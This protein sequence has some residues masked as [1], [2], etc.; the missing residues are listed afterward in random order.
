MDNII[1]ITGAGTIWHDAMMTA[2]QGQPVQQFTD[3]GGVV[4]NRFYRDL[5]VTSTLLPMVR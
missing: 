1:G 5:S 4:Y 2:L 3:P